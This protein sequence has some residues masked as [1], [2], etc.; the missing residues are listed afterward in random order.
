MRR[1]TTMLTITMATTAL[2]AA[3]PTADD[4]WATMGRY[5]GDHLLKDGESGAVIGEFSVEWGVPFQRLNYR[6]HST[7]GDVATTMTGFCHWDETLGK[8]RFIEVETGPD[9]L[10]TSMGELAE[11]VGLMPQWLWQGREGR[12][13]GRGEI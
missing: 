1:L 8:V 3:P 12:A 7:G 11:T 13:K 10:V 2:Q 5:Q 6:Y 9:G 4:W